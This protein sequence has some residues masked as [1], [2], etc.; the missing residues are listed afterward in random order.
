LLA[1]HWA[2]VQD[3][4]LLDNKSNTQ[5]FP[6]DNIYL[7]TTGP[8]VWPLARNKIYFQKKREMNVCP[9]PVGQCVFGNIFCNKNS[10]FPFAGLNVQQQLLSLEF[11]PN[12]GPKLW[13]R[14]EI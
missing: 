13:T 1:Q 14:I 9:T 7:W 10:N 6:D 8:Q 4:K 2:N 12:I 3:I 11:W 5:Q